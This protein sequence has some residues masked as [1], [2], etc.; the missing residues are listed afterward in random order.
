MSDIVKTVK[1]K[2]WGEGQ[3]DFVEINEDDFDP[4]THKKLSDAELAKLEKAADAP[5]EKAA[6]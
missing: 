5:D 1:V 4:K 3:G 2:P 6:E